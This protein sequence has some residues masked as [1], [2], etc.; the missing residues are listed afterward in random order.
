MP[1]TNY[2]LH[3][4]VVRDSSDLLACCPYPPPF[5]ALLR[6]RPLT[7]VPPS[8]YHPSPTRSVRRFLPEVFPRQ[9]QQHQRA[10]R[11]SPGAS[12]AASRKRSGD[13]SGTG[14]PPPRY[15]SAFRRLYG[16]AAYSLAAFLTRMCGGGV[17]KGL[18]LR[19][20]VETFFE[21]VACRGSAAVGSSSGGRCGGGGG[22]AG[23]A[24]AGG[25]APHAELTALA[26]KHLPDLLQC[27]SEVCVCVCSY[28]RYLVA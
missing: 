21:G 2:Y 23:G 14:L 25:S 12:T 18:P 20:L 7:V 8:R 6:S 17:L 13:R 15:G 3:H 26:V 27:F 19:E 10:T 22:G 11:S 28:M 4:V 1:E 5:P 16:D 24:A 9:E